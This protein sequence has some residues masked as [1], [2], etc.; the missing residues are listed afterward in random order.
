MQFPFLRFLHVKQII[1][2]DWYQIGPHPHRCV[3]YTHTIPTRSLL[4]SW[5]AGPVGPVL[6]YCPNH[7]LPVLYDL[8]DMSTGKLISINRRAL[9]KATQG[10]IA[11][12]IHRKGNTYESQQ[13]GLHKAMQG[14]LKGNIRPHGVS[15]G[16]CKAIQGPLKGNIKLCRALPRA[17]Q[18]YIGPPYRATQGHIGPLSF[19]QLVMFFHRCLLLL[20]VLMGLTIFVWAYSCWRGLDCW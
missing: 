4:G 15:L 20:I 19:T 11:K 3:F 14:P 6:V 8:L 2:A 12:P 18:C 17:V 5:S 10:S 13:K 7:P 9:Q 1:K 16:L